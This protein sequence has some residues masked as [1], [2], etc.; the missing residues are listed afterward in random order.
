MNTDAE[1]PDAVG[2]LHLYSYKST[3]VHLMVVHFF[4]FDLFFTLAVFFQT[5]LP[6]LRV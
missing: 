6:F 5:K 1:Q 3:F 2:I 4:Y